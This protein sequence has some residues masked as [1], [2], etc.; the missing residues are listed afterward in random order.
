MNWRGAS[1]RPICRPDRPK[2]S[3]TLA[4]LSENPENVVE[5]AGNFF[6]PAAGHMFGT[7]ESNSFEI[8]VKFCVAKEFSSFHHFSNKTD[9]PF[10]FFWNYCGFGHWHP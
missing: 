10:H 3:K 1:G 4:K 8:W 6:S 7:F 9:I 5:K 2:L